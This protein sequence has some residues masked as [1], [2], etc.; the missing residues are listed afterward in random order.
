MEQNTVQNQQEPEQPPIDDQLSPELRQWFEKY[1]TFEEAQ[2]LSKEEK[3]KFILLYYSQDEDYD[4]Q[5]S[6]I[7]EEAEKILTRETEAGKNKPPFSDEFLIAL[8]NFSKV[9]VMEQLLDE[10]EQ[11]YKKRRELVKGKEVTNKNVAIVTQINCSKMAVTLQ[12]KLIKEIE[13]EAKARELDLKQLM[14]NVIGYLMSDLGVFVEIERFYNLKKVNELKERGD[15]CD[16]ARLRRYIEESIKISQLI[17]E[18]KID[19]SNL[20]LFPHILSDKLYNETG[21]ESEEIV[22]FIKKLIEENKLEDDIVNLI[23][24]EAYSV[25]KTKHKCFQA[26]DQQML[27]AEEHFKK[28]ASQPPPPKKP[29]GKNPLEDPALRKMMKMGFKVPPPGMVTPGMLAPG[30]VPGMEYMAPNNNKTQPQQQEK[31]QQNLTKENTNE[32]QNQEKK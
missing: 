14:G 4:Q 20:F 10:V 8:I 32:K 21:Y 26:F 9:K 28:M 6:Q 7:K 31:E 5:M 23:T 17:M 15:E 25:E 27:E 11:I 2:K 18:D 12:G 30:M 3:Q 13:E 19:Q 16:I 24:K 22:Y 29:Q 1:P